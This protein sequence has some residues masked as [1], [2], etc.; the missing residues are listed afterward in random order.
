MELRL[1]FQKEEIELAWRD[2]LS[3]ISGQ[4]LRQPQSLIQ[5]SML[6]K[7]VTFSGSSIR[8][9][10]HLLLYIAFSPLYLFIYSP[11]KAKK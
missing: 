9:M 5:C 6:I 2:Y 8:L 11:P 10:T 4:C 7:I 1:F 3:S